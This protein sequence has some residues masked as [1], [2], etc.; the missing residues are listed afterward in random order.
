MSIRLQSTSTIPSI[1]VSLIFSPSKL[2][3]EPRAGC[4]GKSYW[5]GTAPLCRGGPC[6]AGYKQIGT[7]N[8]GDGSCCWTGHKV[9]CVCEEGGPTC[10][11]FW[12]GTSPFCAGSCPSTH[13]EAGTSTTGTCTWIPIIG[14]YKPPC[15]T[16][17]KVFCKCN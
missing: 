11:D 2:S 12:A 3:L 7:S 5:S 9:H 10:S 14:C 17:H 8:C 1:S 16:G 6:A 4:A 13:H 15:V